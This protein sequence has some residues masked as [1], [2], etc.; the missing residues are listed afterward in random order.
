M[1]LPFL[2]LR[3]SAHARSPRRDL[4]L[5][6]GLNTAVATLLLLMALGTGAL[7]SDRLD[8]ESLARP[9]WQLFIYSQ[10]IGFSIHG[11]GELPLLLRPAS[12]W[13]RPLVLNLL[14]LAV[15]PLGFGLGALVASLLL[16]A[17]LRLPLTWH[18]WDVLVVA[19]TV[20]VSS[21]A[22]LLTHQRDRLEAERLRAENAEMR[23]TSARLQLLQQQ[24]EPHMLFNTLANAHALIDEEPRQAQ[25]L[26]EALSELLH[27]SM[28]T[29]ERNMVPLREEMALVE[30][31]LR[32]MAIRMGS[33]LRYAL[34]LPDALAPVLLPPL[35]LQPLVENA[36]KHGL[37]GQVQG[38]AVQVRAFVQD[39]QLQVEVLD[40]GAGLPAEALP[41]SH[42]G[43]G[44]SNVRQRLRYAFGTD[45]SVQ[46][47]P[48]PTGGV[49]ALLHIPLTQTR[50]SPHD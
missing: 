13:K 35:T 44:I 24:I 10:C 50:P 47:S 28:Q 12:R 36:I 41:A 25:R 26:L 15:V 33:R 27:A 16:G 3:P 48:R 34:E 30:H 5:V 40:D 38:G 22:I 2:R 29:G 18:P 46:V 31:Y 42:Q 9:W 6:A 17:P 7:Q 19:L 49:R 11:L 39:A 14:R 8:L 20:L 32:L 23:A 45:A 37:D 1:T 4:L 43:I 21:V